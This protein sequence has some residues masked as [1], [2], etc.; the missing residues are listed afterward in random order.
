M[1]KTVLLFTLSMALLSSVC[2]AGTN[3]SHANSENVPK[4]QISC[5]KQK[6]PCCHNKKGETHANSKSNTNSKKGSTTTKT[7]GYSH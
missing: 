6:A 1:K 3:E 2:F 5:V 4:S 7:E